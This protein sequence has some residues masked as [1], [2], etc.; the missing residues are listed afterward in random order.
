MFGVILLRFLEENLRKTK[1]NNKFIFF[2]LTERKTASEGSQCD[3]QLRW[4]C[5]KNSNSGVVVCMFLSDPG[6][7]EVVGTS[8]PSC[9][10]C[11]SVSKVYCTEHSVPSL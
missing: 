4:S 8:S 7:E 11:L 9:G 2:F 3:R 1:I 10:F 6:A 5:M